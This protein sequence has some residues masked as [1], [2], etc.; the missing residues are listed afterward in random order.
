MSRGRE[1]RYPGQ[2]TPVLLLPNSMP[3]VCKKGMWYEHS[4]LALSREDWE[5]VFWRLMGVHS[6]VTSGHFYGM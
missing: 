6:H 4:Y 2:R 5:V 1:W 3:W